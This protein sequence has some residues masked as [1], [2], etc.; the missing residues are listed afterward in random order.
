VK[1]QS[2]PLGFKLLFTD[3]PSLKEIGNWQRN[4]PLPRELLGSRVAL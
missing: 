4:A 2:E 3:S 1:S